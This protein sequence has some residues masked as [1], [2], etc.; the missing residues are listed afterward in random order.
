M[1]ISF[2]LHRTFVGSDM[3]PKTWAS[4]ACLLEVTEVKGD[5]TTR[6]KAIQDDRHS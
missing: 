3:T 2:M 1:F 5:K 6:K 4:T